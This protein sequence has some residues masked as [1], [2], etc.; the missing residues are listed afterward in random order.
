MSRKQ[1]EGIRYY[2]AINGSSCA[3][4]SIPYPGPPRTV[5]R[6]WC[7]IGFPTLDE[8]R[9]AQ[10]L[11]LTAPPAELLRLLH[12]WV[13]SPANVCVMNDDPEPQTKGTTFWMYPPDGP[14]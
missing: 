3:L 10:R 7:L 9:E 4:S 6:C 8:A 1:P 14:V 11:C 13:D 12:L 2:I 5:P